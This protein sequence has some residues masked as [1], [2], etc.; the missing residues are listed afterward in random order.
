MPEVLAHLRKRLFSIYDLEHTDVN[1][2]TT[3]VAV[4][5][6]GTSLYDFGYSRDKRP[7]LRQVN[8]GATELRDPI[9]IPIDLSIDRGNTSDPVRFVKIVDEITGGL[10]DD[11]LFVFDA[12]GD[13]KKV[14]D[15]ITERNTRYITGKRLDVSDGLRISRFDK[16]EAMCVDKNEGVYCQRKMFES[17]GKTVYLFY[18]EKLYRD[19]MAA[20]ERSWRCVEDAKDVMRRDWG[21]CAYR[22]RS[23]NVSRI[24]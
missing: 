6:K 14:L 11:S 7:D 8:F 16:N 13:A 19:K 22:R 18:S 15:R 23:S 9:N 10:R 12:G 4:Y 3:S 2:D 5:T 17:S 21:R 24:L 1:I 20:S